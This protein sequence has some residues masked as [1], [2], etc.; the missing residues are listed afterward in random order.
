MCLVENR[1]LKNFANFTGKHLRCSLFLIKW[2]DFWLADLL[3]RD[4]N[5]GA[6][7]REHSEMFKNA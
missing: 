3:K 7:L 1:G 4:S 5:A 6:L 2:Q